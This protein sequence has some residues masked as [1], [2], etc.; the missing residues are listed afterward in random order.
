MCSLNF[1]P[2]EYFLCTLYSSASVKFAYLELVDL[3]TAIGHFVAYD[4]ANVLDDHGVLLQILSSVQT[5]ALNAGSCQIHVI[6]P[7]RL[8]A[9]ILRR[10]GV[11]K[12]LAVWCVEL[13]GEG[14]LVG[15]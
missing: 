15:L 5:Q 8:Q 14:A 3:L 6:L 13:S 9:P 11:D 4:S 1:N 2:K 7:L 10:L 12:L